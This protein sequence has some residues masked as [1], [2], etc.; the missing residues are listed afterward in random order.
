MRTAFLALPFWSRYNGYDTA[1]AVPSTKEGYNSLHPV[2]RLAIWGFP[3]R[4]TDGITWQ[5]KTG[6]D[7]VT[8]VGPAEARF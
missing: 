1:D 2:Y 6:A 4:N 8:T 3:F 7:N 5:S